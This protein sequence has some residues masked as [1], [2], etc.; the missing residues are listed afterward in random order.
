[1]VIRGVNNPHIWW[2]DDSMLALDDIAAAGANAVRVVWE[3]RGQIAAL[4]EALENVALNGMVPI[5]EL[6]DVTGSADPEALDALVDWWTD[7][8]LVDLLAFLRRKVLVNIANEWGDHTVSAE[9]WRDAYASAIARMRAAGIPHTLVIDA[10][11][12]GQ[13]LDPILTY[14]ASLLAGDPEHNL[15][16]DLHMYGLW[17]GD[18]RPA[19][20]LAAAAD[21]GLPLLVGEFGYDYN[22]GLNNLACRLDAPGLMAAAAERGVGWLAWSW[23]GNNAE[24]AWLDLSTD[25]S[26]DNLTPWG[27][28]VVDGEHGLRATARPASIFAPT[29]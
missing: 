12:W 11:A 17:N 9:A 10:P 27:A 21:A 26:V 24:N 19:E 8:D 28:L 25:W 22:E 7:R 3:T 29:R 1:F 20:A 14:G 23:H 4:E 15:L 18:G 13:G 2:Y 6:H 5:L 16:F